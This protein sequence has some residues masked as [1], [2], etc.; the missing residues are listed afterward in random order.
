MAALA[1]FSLAPVHPHLS[2]WWNTWLP[3][4]GEAQKNPAE[5]QCGSAWLWGA[6]QGA[7]PH[8][9]I[10]WGLCGHVLGSSTVVQE[11]QGIAKHILHIPM[12]KCLGNECKHM[13]FRELL[14]LVST[15]LFSFPQNAPLAP[16]T[17]LS[18]CHLQLRTA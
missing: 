14:I 17:A 6:L 10:L 12:E 8:A 3:Y 4:S 15:Q 1:P 18:V 9:P 16:P 7:Q 11:P 5:R 2:L 13:D